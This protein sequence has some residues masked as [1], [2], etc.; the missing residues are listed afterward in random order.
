[1]R[2][3]TARLIAVLALLLAGCGTGARPGLLGAVG[4]GS[5]QWMAPIA[6]SG[7]GDSA[8]DINKPDNQPA[9]V[10][11]THDGAGP[12]VVVNFD[13]THNRIDTLFDAVGEYKG[14]VLIDLIPEENTTR[15]SVTADGAWDLAVLPLSA[16]PE[17]R[18]SQ[19][20]VGGGDQV[21]RTT[22]D[23][24]GTLILKVY[25]G[26]APKPFVVTGVSDKG[27]ELLVN[28]TGV[29]DG[30]SVPLDASTRLLTVQAG[31][32]WLLTIIPAQ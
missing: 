22:L 16:A 30:G 4:P 12:F 28:E 25:P 24:P 1:M 18:F 32:G 23:G 20:Y 27:R 8:V 5:F 21:V 11:A 31:G 6:L 14:M 19:G 9:L 13:E 10:W 7:T 17:V 26:A 29:Y 2:P 3:R 15:F